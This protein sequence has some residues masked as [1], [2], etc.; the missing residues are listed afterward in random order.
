MNL[1]EVPIGNPINLF[2]HRGDVDIRND[3]ADVAEIDPFSTVQ[4][5]ERMSDADWLKLK[6]DTTFMGLFR[7]VFPDIDLPDHPLKQHG[8]GV[9]HVVGLICLTAL[10]MSEGKRPFWRLPESYLHPSAQ[11][12][13][14]DLVI[15]MSRIR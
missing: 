11:L 8:M 9:K 6:S 15:K 1:S 7:L 13:L 14:G 12:G 10:A 3:L 5:S 2:F 4:F